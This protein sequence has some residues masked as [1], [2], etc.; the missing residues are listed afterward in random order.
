MDAIEDKNEVASNTSSFINERMKFIAAELSS[1][2]DEGQQYKTKYNLV[3]VTSDAMNYLEKESQ[4]DKAITESTIQ[5]SLANFM[6]DYIKT[7]Q[8]YT[9]LLPLILVIHLQTL[10]RKPLFWEWI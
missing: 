5:L 2:E 7:H 9:D 10:E 1:V 3:D 4:T 8:G 6:N